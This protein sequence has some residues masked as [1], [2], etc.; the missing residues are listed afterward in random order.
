MCWFCI[1][2]HDKLGRAYRLPELIPRL[3][4]MTMGT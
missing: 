2:V 4:G 1:D 3:W